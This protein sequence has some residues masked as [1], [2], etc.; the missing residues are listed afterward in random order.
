[1]G[2]FGTNFGG[3][4]AATRAKLTTNALYVATADSPPLLPG[5]LRFVPAGGILINKRFAAGSRPVEFG[6]L[7]RY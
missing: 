4:L 1:M 7:R 6:Y 2:R 5:G 3:L